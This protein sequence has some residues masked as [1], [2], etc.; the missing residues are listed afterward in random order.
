[1]AA[2][3]PGSRFVELEGRNHIILEG[4]PGWRRFLDETRSFL[5]G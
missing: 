2:G 1:M 5:A 3:I 4:D